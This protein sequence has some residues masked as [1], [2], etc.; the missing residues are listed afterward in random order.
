MSKNGIINYVKTFE[1]ALDLL[2][3]NIND[4]NQVCI[5]LDKGEIAYKKLLCI[6]KVL[7]ED[8]VREVQ[9]D[10]Y[11]YE[12]YFLYNNDLG[13]FV[14]LSYDYWNAFSSVGLGRGLYYKTPELAKYCGT[15]FIELWNDLLKSNR[16]KP[17]DFIEKLREQYV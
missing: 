9:S 8:W 2:D 10:E 17:F 6:T 11:Y 4:F 15:Q 14:Y 3:I 12:P 13:S 1:N 7:N 16:R 5:G